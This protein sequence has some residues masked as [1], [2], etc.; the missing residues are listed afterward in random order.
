MNEPQYLVQTPDGTLHAY[1][2]V[3][4][5]RIN[6]YENKGVPIKLYRLK[7]E[8]GARRYYPIDAASLIDAPEKS[9]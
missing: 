9:A 6:L 1:W 3:D 4:I 8:M 7:C 5:L 2:N